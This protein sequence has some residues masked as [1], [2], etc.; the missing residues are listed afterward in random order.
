ML[1]WT[2]STDLTLSN[3]VSVG[4]LDGVASGSV[5]AHGSD[6]DAIE[7]SGWSVNVDE[8]LVSDSY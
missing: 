3:R 5:Q 7:A 1:L 4:R 6:G 2:V 8:S